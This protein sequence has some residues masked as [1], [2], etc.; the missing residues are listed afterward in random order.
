MT[1]YLKTFFT[2]MIF[3]ILLSNKAFAIPVTKEGQELS[4]VLDDMH[5][6]EKWRPGDYVNWLTGRTLEVLGGSFPTHCSE[7]VAAA[8]LRCGIYILQPPD[9]QR[10]LLANAQYYW[11]KKHG[12]RFGWFQV[13]NRIEAQ[14]FANKGCFTVAAFANPHPGRSGHIAIVRPCEKSRASIL[15]F[16]PEIIQAGLENY[17]ST[18]QIVGFG[19]R[20]AKYFVHRT[21]FCKIKTMEI[22]A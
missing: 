11:L 21:Q 10:G 12:K 1:L 9:H 18:A 19:H 14:A 7:F 22:P 16:G 8:A 6:E 15:R 17:N 5:V 3:F 4:Q 20:S 13:K 2:A